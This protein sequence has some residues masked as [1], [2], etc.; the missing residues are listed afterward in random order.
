MDTPNVVLAQ[1]NLRKLKVNLKTVDETADRLISLGVVDKYTLTVE[2]VLERVA[3]LSLDV[4]DAM[5][6]LC[7]RRTLHEVC[8]EKGIQ[9]GS[10]MGG[11]G[12][13]T[14][15]EEIEAILPHIDFDNY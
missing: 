5:D 15:E 13:M 3:D 1:A 10:R 4:Y 11:A 6:I 7:G 9:P 2:R 14:E 8:I 12:T